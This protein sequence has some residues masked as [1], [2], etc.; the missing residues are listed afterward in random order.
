MIKMVTGQNETPM[1]GFDLHVIGFLY[2][3]LF[4]S[5][6]FIQ[7]LISLLRIWIMISEN[8]GMAVLLI[9]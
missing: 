7:K 3:H 2:T 6:F 1:S 8:P 9:S 5:F 4:L